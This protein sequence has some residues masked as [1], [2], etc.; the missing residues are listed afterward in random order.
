[1]CK[2]LRAHMWHRVVIPIALSHLCHHAL[3]FIN[4][5]NRHNCRLI[6]VPTPRAAEFVCKLPK[7]PSITWGA[8]APM[9]WSWLFIYI[10][11]EGQGHPSGTLECLARLVYSYHFP[12]P[13]VSHSLGH[14]YSFD[15]LSRS[16]LVYYPTKA[17]VSRVR[18][19]C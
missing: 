4:F 12:A 7:S 8:V 19:S 6:A 5:R 15:V 14:A 1:M 3:P 2:P 11:F 18:D 16:I 9:S 13:S 17:R 10:R